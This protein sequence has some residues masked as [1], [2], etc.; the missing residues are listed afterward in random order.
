MT[1]SWKSS[2]QVV[3][4]YELSMPDI[5]PWF[6]YC[7]SRP[8]QNYWQILGCRQIRTT[9]F[10]ES[11]HFFL[12]YHIHAFAYAKSIF[13]LSSQITNPL[14]WST[15]RRDLV[16]WTRNLTS[17]T[18]LTSFTSWIL[19]LSFF[20]EKRIGD[21]PMEKHWISLPEASGAFLQK[22]IVANWK[23][24]QYFCH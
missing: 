6:K 1:Y 8:I 22:N 23:R 19:F 16:F 4:M 2:H 13:F 9:W 24:P 14:I 12:F 10:M 11:N 3:A 15:K 7:I 17:L 5:S 20:W 21:S 18:N